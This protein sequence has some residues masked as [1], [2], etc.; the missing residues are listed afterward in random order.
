MGL[1]GSVAL[2]IG[3]SVVDDRGVVRR[4]VTFDIRQADVH[5]AVPDADV[6]G[7]VDD[8][9]HGA[10]RL[11]L[12]R[13]GIELEVAREHDGIDHALVVGDALGTALFTHFAALLL[14]R[15]HLFLTDD[16]GGRH[17]EQQAAEDNYC[18]FHGT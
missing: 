11:A 15:E 17:A 2:N 16:G 18:F 8:L 9:A 4:H 7:R 14:G 13:L 6:E 5:R 10:G 12:H 3:D 1:L